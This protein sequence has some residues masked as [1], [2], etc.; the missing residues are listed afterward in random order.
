MVTKGV[1]SEISKN[2]YVKLQ[3]CRRWLEVVQTLPSAEEHGGPKRRTSKEMMIKGS[4]ARSE[5]KSKYTQ[6]GQ[7]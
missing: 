7:R 2:G 6:G 4:S 5:T 3:D 1:V